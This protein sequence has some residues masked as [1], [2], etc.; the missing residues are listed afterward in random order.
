M[1][2]LQLGCPHMFHALL[3]GHFQA[4]VS[5]GGVHNS[6][7]EGTKVVGAVCRALHHIGRGRRNLVWRHIEGD[8]LA[9]ELVKEDVAV[10]EPPEGQAGEPAQHCFWDFLHPAPCRAVTPDELY[11]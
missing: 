8:C 5:K 4:R 3:K 2:T 10:E 6:L 1:Q 9:H 7:V 11:A